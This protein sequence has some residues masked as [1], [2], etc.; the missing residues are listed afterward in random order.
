[1]PAPMMIYMRIQAYLHMALLTLTIS[2]TPMQ[3][4]LDRHGR[5]HGHALWPCAR[6]QEDA[7]YGYLRVRSVA[8]ARGC[9][10]ACMHVCMYASF[11][12]SARITIGPRIAGAPSP[13]MLCA[14]LKC[15]SICIAWQTYQTYH[16]WLVRNRAHARTYAHATYVHAYVHIGILKAFAG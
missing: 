10:Q 2:P 13:P 11:T 6:A 14:H 5:K 9:M 8:R 3:R 16:T 1:M 7:R 4:V 12:C 15:S